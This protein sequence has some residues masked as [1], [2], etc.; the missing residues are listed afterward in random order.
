[1]FEKN[2]KLLL[3][4]NLGICKPGQLTIIIVITNAN[5][6]KSSLVDLLNHNKTVIDGFINHTTK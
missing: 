1:M 3:S 6:K 4:N 2:M 5:I